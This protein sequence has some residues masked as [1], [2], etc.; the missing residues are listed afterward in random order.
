MPVCVCGHVLHEALSVDDEIEHHRRAACVGRR[1]V[2]AGDAPA[3]G[4]A[5]AV[6]HDVE[7]GAQVGFKWRAHRQRGCRRRVVAVVQ[8]AD[9]LVLVHLRVS[10]VS[11]HRVG[12]LEGV[13]QDGRFARCDGIGRLEDGCAAVSGT[14]VQVDLQSGGKGDDADVLHRDTGLHEGVGKHAPVCRL[15]VLRE[16]FH[17]AYDG[18]GQGLVAY[19]DPAGAVAMACG[20]GRE[21]HRRVV[22]LRLVGQCLDGHGGRLLS[23]GD[24]DAVGVFQAV[25]IVA[26]DADGEGLCRGGVARD[27]EGDALPC[28]L[29]HDRAV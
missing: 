2:K 9:A 13:G 1:T 6:L 5:V 18:V 26:R 21:D 27:G 8:L 28:A 11:A 19:R 14:L 16:Q 23:P 25:V 15:A 20:L 17:L 7:V 29:E 3:D 22:V 24:G 4:H 10:A 12:G